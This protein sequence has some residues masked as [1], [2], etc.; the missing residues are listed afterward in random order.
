MKIYLKE[1]IGDPNL[2]C[3]RKKE[4][5]GLLLWV[6]KI[7]KELSPSRSMVSRRKT[8]KTAI[9]QRLFNI[10]FHQNDKVVPFYYEV[11]ETSQWAV[12]FCKDFFL[13][14]IYQYVAFRSRNSEY[15]SDDIERRFSVAIDIVKKE[16]FDFLVG[17]IETVQELVEEEN[18]GF[19]WNIVRDAP[20]KIAEQEDMRVM[21]IIDEFQYLNRKIY[22]DKEAQKYLI[23]DFAQGYMSTAEY[24]NAPLIVAGSW[25]GWLMHDIMK[26]PAR[27]QLTTLDNMPEDEAVEMVYRYSSLYEI[28]VTDETAHLIAKISEGSPFYISGIMRSLYPDKDLTTRDGVLATL[29]YETLNRRGSIYN[30]WMEYIH[31][32]FS[33]INDRNAKKIVLYLCKN[34]DREITRKELI[35][36]VVPDMDDYG[37]EKKLKTLVY[38]DIIE[39]GSTNFRYKGVSDNIFDKVF[40]GVYAEEIEDFDPAEITNEYKELFDKIQK[41]YKKLQGKHNYL[42][43]K[44]AEFTFI[45]KL[46]YHAFKENEKFKSMMKNLPENFEFTEYESVWSWYGSPVYRKNIQIDIFARAKDEFY[47]LVGEIK[48]RKDTKFSKAEAEKFVEKAKTMMEIEEIKKAV[49]FVFSQA[50]FTDEA[51][52]FFKNKNI[53]WTTDVRWIQPL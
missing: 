37:L 16:G 31:Y 33:T 24:K 45:L 18:S 5:E 1:K 29:E 15:L 41:K 7:K 38:S 43:G 9:L 11:G 26:M 8:G 27:F 30:T 39:Q 42:T 28:P 6:K 2:F 3:G 32:A 34:R 40:R 36:K 17:N 21:Q 4:L 13:S 49:L 48:K 35:E 51:L 14:F 52:E 20:R 47:S 44:Y 22:R 46:T 50:G 23:K 10:V 12:D 19:L 53:A 25:V